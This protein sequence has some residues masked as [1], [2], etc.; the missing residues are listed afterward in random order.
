M[1]TIVKYPQTITQETTGTFRAFK[2]L[3]NIKNANE[4]YAVSDGRI[5]GKSKTKRRPARLTCTNFGFNLPVGA[6]I[7]NIRVEYAHQ[8]LEYQQNKFP[9]I[10]APLFRL[11]NT[12]LRFDEDEKQSHG[13]APTNQMVDITRTYN[14]DAIK[15]I[16]VSGPAMS[17]G[18]M[19]L[20]STTGTTSQTQYIEQHR[21]YTL[22]KY[23]QINSD[24]F[25][26][27]F[28]YPANTSENEG[29][30]RIK[31]IRI[32][33][34]YKPSEYTFNIKALKKNTINTIVETEIEVTNV[35]STRHTPTIELTLPS[36]AVLNRWYGTGTLTP[37]GNNK[38]LW[39]SKVEATDTGATLSSVLHLELTFSSTGTNKKLSI[40]ET[41][42]NAYAE[43]I[44]EIVPMSTSWAEETGLLPSINEDGDITLDTIFA[45]VNTD[46][47]VTLKIPSTYTANTIR[48]YGDTSLSIKTGTS[49]YTALSLANPYNISK[50]YFT[51][52]EYEITLKA[53]STGIKDIYLDDQTGSYCTIKVIPASLGYPSMSIKKLTQSE[54]NYMGDGFNY[55]VNTNLKI[56]VDTS[57]ISHF[58]NYYR[59]FRVGV[60]N[61][62][63]PSN[64]EDI[65]AYIFDHTK[66][67]SEVMTAFNEY[68]NKTIEFNY[69]KDYPVY[70]IYT[71]DFQGAYP[72]EFTLYHDAPL[73]YESTE[74][75]DSNCTLPT[76]LPSVLA[77]DST[78]E[79]HIPYLETTNPFVLYQ[80]PIPDYFE[81][82]SNMA[83]RGIEVQ[84]NI[85]NTE[86]ISITATLLSPTGEYG[87][88]SFFVDGSY[89]EQQLLI[90][91][92]FDL[93]GFN[94]SDIT[95]IEDWTLLLQVNN[96]SDAI[97][98]NVEV[99]LNN[100]TITF[101]FMDI[102]DQIVTV[103]INGEDVRWYGA[104][105][106]Q[107]QK[108]LPG[109]N[110]DI[111]YLEVDG[112]D[113]NEA[114]RQ[115]IK[116]KEFT[117]EFDLD[118]CDINETTQM[119]KQLT[120]LLT[121][122]RDKFN[123][124][125]PNIIEFSHW[126][127]EHWEYLLQSAPEPDIE[128]TSYTAKYKI[129]IPAGTSY[130][131]ND[132]ITGPVGIVNAITK[133]NPI[134]IV[135]KITND[136]VELS[137]TETN[138]SFR[139]NYPFTADDYVEIDCINRKVFLT[140]EEEVNDENP[141]KDITGYVDFNS[142]WFLLDGRYNFTSN[143][144]KIN[145]IKYNERG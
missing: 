132:T 111:K 31:Y 62:T 102:L 101:H 58:N 97:N 34:T 113:T 139:I 56:G 47:T 59:N 90:G 61:D 76:E 54:L 78:A 18:V 16:Q 108:I 86:K 70:I 68:E 136:S 30:L 53:N 60:F 12:D 8:K 25:G 46:F 23:T 41:T 128:V 88:K 65:Q 40:A 33:I 66:T 75:Y 98:T 110:T 28:N 49:S 99:I 141:G 126:P 100:L 137:E 140:N 87:S 104:Y 19:T 57:N 43:H 112:T 134:I 22:P 44:F 83:I 133:I 94:I 119:L 14:G 24:K 1:P 93:W 116:E 129:V 50:T 84:M 72:T 52:N 20:N 4:T 117:I 115:T 109:L 27:M 36:G 39:D 131:N 2:D 79:T 71:G 121:N 145:Q 85:T 29:W 64:T 92:N 143:D 11:M 6:E 81:T 63:I 67:W 7:T 69:N 9:A 32:R 42:T 107:D 3:N 89:D 95:N 123:R 38:Y 105:L 91:G 124:P 135:N 21:S 51:N 138:Q 96:N 10:G 125:I 73:L 48:L 118:G 144:C 37:Q 103:R 142:D 45:V 5:Q 35:N 120:Q 55:T 13:T 80:F 15:I 130:A 26:I 82:S 17:T 77:T 114:T 74:P 127:G 106:T 122:K